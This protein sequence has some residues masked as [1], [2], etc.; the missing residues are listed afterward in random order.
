M[1]T[2]LFL[3]TLIFFTVFFDISA[4]K[5][6]KKN[7]I[8]GKVTDLYNS[9]VPGAFIMIDGKNIER[10]TDSKGF[11]KI[12]VKSS[13]QKI[14]IFTTF[15]EVKEEPI[16]GRTIINFNL[17]K[18]VPRQL[19][20][21]TSF[22]D[23]EVVNEGY[24][25]SRKRNIT[26]PVTKTDVSGNEYASFSSIYEILKTIPGL[27]VSGNRVTVRGVNTTGSSTPLFV[28]N[29][30]PVN[31]IDAINPSMVKSIE[32]LKGPSGSVYG[33]QGANGVIIIR[34]KGTD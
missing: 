26:N 10:K 4:Q 8:T 34:L 6:N 11:F 21:G 25:V 22:S 28:V 23:D 17:D 15:A 18:I 33:L 5:G 20:A 3:L 16:N 24:N 1:K 32:V 14:G 9:P 7:T 19:N 13:A 12:K 2:K 31:S 29:G 27:T 30:T